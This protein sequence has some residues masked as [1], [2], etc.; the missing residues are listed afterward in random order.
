M[1]KNAD[2]GFHDGFQTGHF[3]SFADTGFENTQL[4]S[5]F[6]LPKG[7]GESKLR[8]ITFRGATNA[9]LRFEQPTE[10]VFYNGFAIAARDANHW[11]VKLLSVRRRQVLQSPQRIIHSY[12]AALKPAFIGEKIVVHHKSAHPR[13]VHCVYII[14]PIS[15][16]C[17]QS[18]KSSPVRQGNASTVVG[19]LVHIVAKTGFKQAAAG[20]FY[21]LV[22]AKAHG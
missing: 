13:L 20:D 2:F 15:A 11:Y 21:D 4:I 6:E 10:P 19:Q 17:A 8:I 1:G 9:Q 16:S 7:D 3:V 5:R 14:N 22:E 18:K 12:K